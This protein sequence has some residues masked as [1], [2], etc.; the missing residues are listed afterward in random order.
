MGSKVD[1]EITIVATEITADM[2]KWYVDVGGKIGETE[3]YDVRGQVKTT[4]LVA[5][6]N[7]RTSYKMQNDSG[8]Y[9]IRFMGEDSEVALIFL[10]KFSE[11][12]F[13]HNMKEIEKYD[14]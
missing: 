8:Q 9:L 12:V 7:G 14:Y 13:T 6:G 3:Y 5:Y 11:F 2:M 4:P 1:Y 10:M